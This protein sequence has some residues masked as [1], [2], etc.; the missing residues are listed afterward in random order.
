MTRICDYYNMRYMKKNKQ[1]SGTFVSHVR[2]NTQEIFALSVLN[3]AFILINQRVSIQKTAQVEID[4]SIR[5]A[6]IAFYLALKH[7]FSFRYEPLR[8]F[9]FPNKNK[10]FFKKPRQSTGLF[11]YQS[12]FIDCR[13]IQKSR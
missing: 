13:I 1:C 4:S 11:S 12:V 3:K 10:V 9:L 8:N 5:N 6:V 2:P 7:M